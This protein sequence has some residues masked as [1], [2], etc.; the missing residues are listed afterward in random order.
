MNVHMNFFVKNLSSYRFKI[1]CEMEFKYKQQRI[2]VYLWN[3]GLQNYRLFCSFDRDSPELSNRYNIFFAKTRILLLSKFRR[4]V[5]AERGQTG[6]LEL[7]GEPT[8]KER[9]RCPK[10]ATN[11]NLKLQ[12]TL[13]IFHLPPTTW[14]SGLNPSL[15]R[16]VHIY[17]KLFDYC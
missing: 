13:K 2:I 3:R 7:F 11:T 5:H 9:S 16:F 6:V 17:L 8:Q 10:V 12:L 15:F 14:H 1:F 4:Q